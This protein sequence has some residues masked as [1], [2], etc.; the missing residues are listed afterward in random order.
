VEGTD[1]ADGLEAVSIELVVG[2]KS[3]S[4]SGRFLLITLAR[5]TDT[6]PV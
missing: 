6:R 4:I 3:T 2:P 5:I 1:Q